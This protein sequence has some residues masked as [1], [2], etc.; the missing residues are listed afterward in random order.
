MLRYATTKGIRVPRSPNAPAHS[1]RSKRLPRRRGATESCKRDSI[2]AGSSRQWSGW[3]SGPG[4]H[5]AV[6]ALRFL[7][8]R[9]GHGAIVGGRAVSRHANCQGKLCAARRPFRIDDPS[10]A[11]RQ[12]GNVDPRDVRRAVL[13]AGEF[14]DRRP[15]DAIAGQGPRPVRCRRWT[16]LRRAPGRRARLPEMLRTVVER[17]T[18]RLGAARGFDHAGDARGFRRD[19]RRRLARW[20]Q[21]GVVCAGRAARR[22]VLQRRRGRQGSRRHRGVG[23]AAGPRCRGRRGGAHQRADRRRAATCGITGC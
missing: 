22:G 11:L 8:E 1:M 12:S 13:S 5:P 7:A 14:G 15:H 21:F 6:T 4:G 18:A 16:L 10:P 17:G 19:R 20:R 9:P 3:P 23:H 2:S